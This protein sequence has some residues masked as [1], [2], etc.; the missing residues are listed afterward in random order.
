ML[1]VHHDA[2]LVVEDVGED[3]VR[4]GAVG[5]LGLGERPPSRG[6]LPLVLDFL[7]QLLA[8]LLLAADDPADQPADQSSRARQRP[9]QPRYVSHGLSPSRLAGTSGA[10]KTSHATHATT[11]AHTT[12]TASSHMPGSRGRVEFEREGAL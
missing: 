4:P 1:Q 11:A 9:S 12:T 8:E 10:R 6:Y 2:A 7:A 3:L 5:L